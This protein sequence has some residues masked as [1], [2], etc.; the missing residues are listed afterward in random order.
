MGMGSGICSMCSP[1]E[2]RNVISSPTSMVRRKNERYNVREV[3][4]P[5]PSPRS[6][7]TKRWCTVQRQYTRMHVVIHGKGVCGSHGFWS[8]ESRL[9][10][11]R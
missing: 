10:V 8:R 3:S 7:N 1:H 9:S 5:T 2:M 11:I 6:A 4:S